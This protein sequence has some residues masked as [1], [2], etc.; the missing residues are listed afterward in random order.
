MTEQP[1]LTMIRPTEIERRFGRILRAPDHDAGTAEGGDGGAEGGE[2]DKIETGAVEGEKSIIGAIGAEGEKKDEGAGE[3]D[4]SEKGE[5]DG[6]KKEGEEEKSEGA[7]EK[8]EL[9]APEGLEINDE[10]LAEVDPI[11]RELGLSNE[12]A[13]KIMPLAGKFHERIV[14]AQID[15]H[16]AMGADW[17]KE[18]RTDPRIGGKHWGET[19]AFV[20]RALDTV[21]AGLGKDGAKE[22]AGFK[23]LL[24]ATQLGNNPTM[25]KILRWYGERVGEDGNFVRADAGA[26]IKQP[27]EEVLYPD[28]VPKK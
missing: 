8:Y 22:V 25:I 21:S 6:E 26:A 9:T 18:A 13:N 10:I 14:A 27:R 16:K 3:G 7:P 1:K 17:A 15:A 24:D 12:A 23:D 11:F 19:E 20:A 4:Q 2:G 28:D 5:A